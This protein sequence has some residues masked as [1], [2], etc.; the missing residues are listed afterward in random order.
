MLRKRF[1]CVRGIHRVVVVFAL[2][3]TAI[4]VD[5]V[6]KRTHD[7]AVLVATGASINTHVGEYRVG[8]IDIGLLKVVEE[9]NSSGAMLGFQFVFHSDQPLPGRC[10]NLFP[11][12]AQNISDLVAEPGG[13]FAERYRSPGVVHEHDRDDRDAAD[14]WIRAQAR[15]LH[16]RPAG[17]RYRGIQG[18]LMDDSLR[19]SDLGDPSGVAL[20]QRARMVDLCQSRSQRSCGIGFESAADDLELHSLMDVSDWLDLLAVRGARADPRIGGRR[21]LHGSLIGSRVAWRPAWVAAVAAVIFAVWNWE[22]MSVDPIPHAAAI[23]VANA[24][25]LSLTVLVA[26][27]V[28]VDELGTFDRTPIQDVPPGPPRTSPPRKGPLTCCGYYLS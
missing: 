16:R 22:V 10:C 15:S 18:G 12:Q 20:A 25:L 13:T 5:A 3:G 24:F 8:A 11:R 27:V 1:A 26:V 23:N 28:A 14:G 6:H 17:H 2:A 21:S 4:V 9:E 7:P 19:S